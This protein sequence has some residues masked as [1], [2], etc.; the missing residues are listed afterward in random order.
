MI[1]LKLKCRHKHKFNIFNFINSYND[2]IFGYLYF[3]Y[4]NK[5]TKILFEEL[6]MTTLLNMHICPPYEGN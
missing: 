4:V 5:G 2:M 3:Y 1:S 6:S